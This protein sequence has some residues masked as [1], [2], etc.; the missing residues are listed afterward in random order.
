MKHVGCFNY[1]INKSESVGKK[2]IKKSKKHSN[3]TKEKGSH[4][5]TN[6]FTKEIELSKVE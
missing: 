2:Y 5:N 3:C 4:S 1:F 6:L